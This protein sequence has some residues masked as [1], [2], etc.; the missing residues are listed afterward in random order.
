MWRDRQRQNDKV[1]HEIIAKNYTF[2]GVCAV[3]GVSCATLA[4]E[5]ADAVNAVRVIITAAIVS[6]TFVNVYV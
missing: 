2:A 5:A 4:S 3:S 1:G 6:C